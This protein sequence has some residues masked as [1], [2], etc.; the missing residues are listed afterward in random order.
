MNQS[1]VLAGVLDDQTLPA[2]QQPGMNNRDLGRF[3]DLRLRILP[4]RFASPLPGPLLLP[5]LSPPKRL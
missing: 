1:V 4:K 5:G 2:T 3:I